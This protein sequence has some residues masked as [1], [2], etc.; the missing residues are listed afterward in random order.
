MLAFTESPE[1]RAATEAEAEVVMLYAGMLGRQP[2]PGGFAYWASLRRAGQPLGGLVRRD[3][4]VERVPPPAPPAVG[5]ALRIRGSTWP[6]AISCQ[7][8]ARDGR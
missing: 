7:R 2:D 1:H 8:G 3:P 5:S 6:G 4:R